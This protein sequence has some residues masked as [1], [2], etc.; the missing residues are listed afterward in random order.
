MCHNNIKYMSILKQTKDHLKKIFW[1][2]NSVPFELFELAQYF[3]NNGPIHFEF[4]HE[5]GEIIAISK[6]FRYGSIVTSVKS[7]KELDEKVKDAILTA[8]D[9]PSSYGKEAAIHRVKQ[10][11]GTG[12]EKECVYAFA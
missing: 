1:N 9:V 12:Q 2:G 5:D 7:Q 10:K 11:E 3:R 8:F 6:D 4:K